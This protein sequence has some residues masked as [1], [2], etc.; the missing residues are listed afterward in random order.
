MTK[1]STVYK[2]DQDSSTCWAY[3]KHMSKNR[4][5]EAKKRKASNEEEV[6]RIT[7]QKCKAW[8]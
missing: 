3:N 5:K 7:N 2:D 6:D 1:K 8:I 4:I